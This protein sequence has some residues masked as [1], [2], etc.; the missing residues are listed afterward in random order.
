MCWVGLWPP[1]PYLILP[2]LGGRQCL[3]AWVGTGVR[4]VAQLC[5][6]FTEALVSVTGGGSEVMLV[7]GEPWAGLAGGPTW[8]GTRLLQHSPVGLVSPRVGPSQMC[9]K[10]IRILL[11]FSVFGNMGAVMGWEGFEIVPHP[12]RAGAF[13]WSDISGPGMRITPGVWAL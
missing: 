6:T 11:A 1:L 3:W 12:V 7:S 4:S 2:S 13:S 8:C 10:F 5:S 9:N